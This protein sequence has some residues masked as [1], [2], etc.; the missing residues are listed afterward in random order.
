MSQNSY[1]L[2]CSFVF[3]KVST[4]NN[5]NNTCCI[6]IIL[7]TCLHICELYFPPLTYIM[8][9][10]CFQGSS[11]CWYYYCPFILI[12]GP[13]APSPHPNPH[14]SFHTSSFPLTL[15]PL[16]PSPAFFLPPPCLSLLSV[17]WSC[18]LITA[19]LSLFVFIYIFP[20]WG[21]VRCVGPV[22]SFIH[23]HTSTFSP[24]VPVLVLLSDS[25]FLL[26]LYVCLFSFRSLP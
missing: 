2:P 12:P 4:Y 17:S 14:S 18:Y 26:S 19:A 21:Y 25:S 22:P 3:F 16:P 11:S 1:G 9:K 13:F 24:S 20:V 23:L 7:T 8:L 6:L 10:G 5:N 15:I